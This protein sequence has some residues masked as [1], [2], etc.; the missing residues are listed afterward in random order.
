[1]LLNVH[2]WYSLR[3]GTIPMEGL[4]DLLLRKGYDSAVITDI[5][6]STGVLEFIKH[7]QAKG[8]R[9]FA[10]MEFRDGD[11][12]LYF[13]I[14][15]NNKGFVELNELMT[16]C[17]V[18][19]KRLPETAPEF[20]H[21]SVVYPFGSKEYSE[22]RDFEYIGVQ[23]K[24]LTKLMLSPKAAHSKYVIWKPITFENEDGHRL[25]KQLRAINRNI[26]LSQLQPFQHAGTSELLCTKD[27]LLAQY[28][29]FPQIIANTEHLLW[30]CSFQFD[31]ESVKN[32][33]TYT[34]TVYGD[35]EFLEMLALNGCKE[36]Y[37]RN[38]ADALNRVRKEL[39]TIHELGFSSYFLTTWDI[40]RETMRRGFYHV[41]RGSGANSVVAYCL[42]I[43]DVCPIELDLYFERFL[44]R[45]RKS[46]PDFDLDFSWKDRDE[47]FRYIF[48]RYGKT[49]TA[50]LGAMST[51]RDRSSIRELGKV[52]GL[53]KADI[54]RLI[55]D[56]DAVTNKNE[57]TDLILSAY[58]QM[59]DFPNNRTIHAGGV[60]I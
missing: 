16:D 36:R 18:N 30:D 8:L 60:L 50:L 41:G 15:K 57:I 17:N 32:K 52:Y 26:L 48:G 54:D 2:S 28:K 3:Y 13:C 46:P 45:K 44:N 20:N 40:I 11:R 39:E 33:R 24:H 22:L 56:P 37:G 19:K 58:K 25:H 53:P 21:V 14:A 51:F 9:G 49:H 38:N 6:C 1:M 5:N 34:G 4:A 43:T 10:G 35:K 42:K 29:D 59:A 47:V 27:E 55:E 7:C 31:F 12:L 23:P